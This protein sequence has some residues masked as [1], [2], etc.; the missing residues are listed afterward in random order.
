MKKFPRKEVLDKQFAVVAEELEQEKLEAVQ[1]GNGVGSLA[2][3]L[4]RGSIVYGVGL[5]IANQIRRWLGGG[6]NQGGST[7]Q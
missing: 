5:P 4:M 2:N 3:T 6:S 1:G 7:P